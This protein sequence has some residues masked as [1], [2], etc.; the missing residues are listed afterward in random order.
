MTQYMM[1]VHDVV[2]EETPRPPRRAAEDVRRD[3]RVQRQGPRGRQVGLRR[4][5]GR[6]RVG[7][8]RRRHG[9]QPSSPTARS[10]SPRST[11][12]ASGSSRQPTSTRPSEWATEGSR[13]AAAGRGAALP[14]RADEHS[15]ADL[16]AAARAHPSRGVRR[17]GGLAGPALRRHRPRRGRRERGPRGG[18]R[19]LADRRD[20][21]EPRRL[22]HHHRDPQG[23][24]PDPPRVP[25]R[26]QAPAGS[27]D[28]RPTHPARAR[29]G[30]RRPV[31]A[32]LHLL[33]P[34]AVAGGPGR[35]HAQA[36]R[37]PD[38]EEIAA[39][40]LV[41]DTTMAQRIT[42]AKRKISDAHIPYRVPQAADLPA[43]LGGVLA[44]VYL[45]F[46]EGYLS[47]SGADSVRDDLC[48][49]AIRLARLLRAL[50]PDRAGDHRAARPDAPHRGPSP[51]PGRR[52]RARH[53]RRAGPRPLGPRARS[54]RATPSSATAWRSTGPGT[55][56]CSPRST[57][58]TPTRPPRPTPTGRQIA[59]LYDQLYAVS[60]TPIVALNRAVALAELDGPVVA[61]AAV[62]RLRC[63]RTTPGMPPGP[64]SCAASAAA[65]RPARRTTLRS[66]PPTTRPS[67]PSSGD[68]SRDSL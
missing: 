42:R 2:D 59:A 6:H 18:P 4:R 39:A 66:R 31:A 11:S 48:L 33:P 58:C 68:P 22:A 21:P 49:E 19:A 64:T 55:T 13:P 16:A 46:N 44:V 37:R 30:R 67:E 47:S 17:S 65:A 12:A 43:R 14:V 29:R 10:R 40:F 52:R 50:M 57:P 1:S 15:D 62:D 54:R 51:G 41:P 53:P 20:P 24:R 3:R 32:A 5:A 7:H 36:D 60:P 27:D 45:I 63:R 9:G 8:H 35:P 26:H 61:L 38:G 25:P 28:H 34:G 23:D 56:S